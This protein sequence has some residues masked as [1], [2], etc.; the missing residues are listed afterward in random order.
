M[1]LR[2]LARVMAET[3]ERLVDTL[4]NIALELCEAGSVGLSVLETLPT[5]DEVFHWTNLVGAMSR[6]AG[7]ITPKEQNAST[8]RSNESVLN[9]FCIQHATFRTPRNSNPR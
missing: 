7:G 4:L 5:G 6:F 2:K 3:P 8:L 1:A 9:C